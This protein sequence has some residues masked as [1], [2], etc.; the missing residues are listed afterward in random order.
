MIL[1]PLPR[2][3]KVRGSNRLGRATLESHATAVG[4]AIPGETL[5][6]DHD[7]L[8]PALPFAHERRAGHVKTQAIKKGSGKANATSFTKEQPGPARPK[9]VRNTSPRT[10]M[11]WRRRRSSEARRSGE[12]GLFCAPAAK[13]IT[14]RERSSPAYARARAAGTLRG[15]RRAGRSRRPARQACLRRPVRRAPPGSGSSAPPGCPRS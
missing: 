8:E 5:L 10:L 11:A 2:Q 9:G 6:Q 1:V 12:R 7:P 13:A 3:A 14:A 15:R 4:L